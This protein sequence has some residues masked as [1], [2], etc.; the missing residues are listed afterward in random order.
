MSSDIGDL[1]IDL[2]AD[3]V[4]GGVKPRLNAKLFLES[5]VHVGD[6]FI[7]HEVAVS[8]AVISKAS[9]YS[10]PCTQTFR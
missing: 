7:V 9:C 10:K 4:D 1:G 3:V 6:S 8:E 2:A 5:M